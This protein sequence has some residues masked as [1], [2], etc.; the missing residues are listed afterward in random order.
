MF[1]SSLAP[2]SPKS[3]ITEGADLINCSRTGE[4]FE[5]LVKALTMANGNYLG[6]N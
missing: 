4:V 2:N 6:I 3:N 1:A 5:L